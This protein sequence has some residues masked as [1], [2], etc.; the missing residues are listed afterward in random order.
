MCLA[1]GGHI[2]RCF[3]TCISSRFTSKQRQLPELFKFPSH[4]VVFY[5]LHN[6]ASLQNST[7][8]VTI[9]SRLARTSGNPCFETEDGGG[10]GSGGTHQFPEVCA[11]LRQLSSRSLLPLL[12]HVPFLAQQ[13]LSTERSRRVLPGTLPL[14]PPFCLPDSGHWQV[15]HLLSVLPLT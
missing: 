3:Y 14:S 7:D 9:S 4:Q 10:S 13:P 11:C 5:D 1:R 12:R 8:P 6:V 2:C 15:W